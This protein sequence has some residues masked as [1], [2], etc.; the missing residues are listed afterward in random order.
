MR[1][2][3]EATEL[4][5]LDA[6]EP[7]PRNPRQGDIGAIH[8]SMQDNGW[9][10]SII[11]QKSSG[12]IIAGNHRYRAAQQVGMTEI[13]VT[14][15]DVDDDKALRILLADN[16]ANDRASYDDN[17]LVEILREL[18]DTTGT[19]AGTLYEDDDLAELLARLDYNFEPD[20]EGQPRLDEKKKITCPNCEHEFEPA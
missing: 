11:V 12:H 4:V 14:W 10:G 5:P 20:E 6:I 19:L 17:E 8:E 15:V 1:N 18:H 7:H 9:Y 13:P 3:N 16:R 2:P